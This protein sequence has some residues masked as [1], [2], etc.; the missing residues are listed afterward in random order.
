MSTPFIPED[1]PTVATRVRGLTLTTQLVCGLVGFLA[2]AHK[3]ALTGT[4]QVV[5]LETYFVVS[6]FAAV[7]VFDRVQKGCLGRLVVDLSALTK[8]PETHFKW[9]VSVNTTLLVAMLLLVS[10]TE[11]A[12]VT[13][14]KKHAFNRIEI[15][16]VFGSVLWGAH[17]AHSTI[18]YVMHRT[19]RSG[20]VRVDISGV[21]Q[22]LLDENGDVS[23]V[24]I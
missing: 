16:A 4:A 23:C 12:R 15:A 3:C 17:L 11:D 20:T 21:Y 22:T 6:V 7:A 13:S 5:G 19:T 10:N 14:E 1:L 24:N 8:T 2:L 18:A 9:C